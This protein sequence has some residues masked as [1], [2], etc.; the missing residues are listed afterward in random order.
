MKNVST[1]TIVR[2]L[3]RCI[4]EMSDGHLVEVAAGRRSIAIFPRGGRDALVQ[5]NPYFSHDCPDGAHERYWEQFGP[6]AVLPSPV[7]DDGL[8]EL[9]IDWLDQLQALV[10]EDE[11]LDG[12]WEALHDLLARGLVS[13]AEEL[14]KTALCRDLEGEVS[15]ALDARGI[16]Y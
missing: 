7:L 1:K 16:E 15:D 3:K 11:S 13:K 8:Y 2:E 4:R 14:R 5:H 9:P 10:E 12:H 6:R